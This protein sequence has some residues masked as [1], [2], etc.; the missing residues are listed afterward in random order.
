MEDRRWK[1]EVGVVGGLRLEVRGLMG[2]D[3]R[4]EYHCIQYQK[5]KFRKRERRTFLGRQ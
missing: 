3:L 5:G 4:T 1:T 2:R